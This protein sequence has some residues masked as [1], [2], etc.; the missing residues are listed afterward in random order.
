MSAHHFDPLTQI[1]DCGISRA[2]A[3]DRDRVHCPA[4][5]ESISADDGIEVELV[6][7]P[8]SLVFRRPGAKLLGLDAHGLEALYARLGQL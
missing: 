3:V 1:C 2:E 4:K 6:L 7:L 8:G 5:R